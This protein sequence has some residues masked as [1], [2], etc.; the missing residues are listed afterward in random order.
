MLDNFNSISF[1]IIAHADDWQLFMCPNVT[2]DLLSRS[3][4]I[5]F[6]ITT[7][8]DSGMNTQYWNAREEGMKS[9]LRFCLAPFGNFSEINERKDIKGHTIC[10]Y[11]SG[12]VSCYFLRLPDGNLDGSGFA[13]NNFQSL[14][15]LKSGE[16]N[17]ITAI[18]N[19]TTYSSWED[20]F[21]TLQTIIL[22]ESAG[23]KEKF[24]NYQHPD[25]SFNPNDHADHIAT[26]NA[27]SS[28]PVI[29]EMNQ[30]LFQGYATGNLANTLSGE[31]IFW[32]A[33]MFAAYEKAVFDISGYSTLQEGSNIYRN[34]CLKSANYI[35]IRPSN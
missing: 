14:A 10:F 35:E 22:K 34:W 11:K 27:I 21:I 31:D 7:A 28:M 25:I 5:V 1:Y 8:G 9:S 12:N 13:S 32:K 29:K 17:A 26:G 30:A 18:D 2:N 23:I 6:I 4:K 19:S 33:G 15:K 20:F 24:I 16:I 3:D